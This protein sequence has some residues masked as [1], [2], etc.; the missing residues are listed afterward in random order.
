MT[1]APAHTPVLLD[2]VV[3]ALAPR[4]QALYVDGTFGGGGY[5]RALLTAARCR[6]IGIDRD[7]SAIA[8]G[9]ALAQEHPDRL[10]LI[11]GR[12][13]EM[14]ALLAPLGIGSGGVSGGIVLDL[15]VSSP[16]LDDPRRG[17][18]F[19]ADGPLDM[20]M[21]SSGST[22]AD[23]VNT[24]PEAALS[25]LIYVYGEERFS[26]RVARAIAEA[27]QKAPLT[28]T[29][30]LAELVRAV[31][32]ASDGID[33]A[34][35][36][37]Q[38]LRIEVNDELGELERALHTA[39]RLLAAGGRLAIVSFHSLEDRRVKDFLRE[40]SPTAPRGSRHRPESPPRPP[41][42]RLL[43]RKPVTSDTAEIARN[44]R[45]RSARLRAA[46]RTSAPPWASSEAA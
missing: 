14:A 32:P 27:R 44:P 1:A 43:N 4:D 29:T 34:T 39:E 30:E 25:K 16:Q 31:V 8:A 19:R 20:R 18:S 35:R 2:E 21:G 9:A 28:R 33:P 42:F 37:F 6:V 17:F 12:F 45:S 36:T 26:R 7:P 10:A 41:S 38:A 5:A 11:E 24:L 46:E 13:G 23:L 22:A 3:A 15:G 40:R